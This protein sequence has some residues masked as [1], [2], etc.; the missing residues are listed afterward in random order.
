MSLDFW[1][2]TGLRAAWRPRNPARYRPL[3]PGPRGSGR[4][5]RYRAGFRG[6]HAALNPVPYQK[7]NDMHEDSGSGQ[8]PLPNPHRNKKIE[9]Q[10]PIVETD[11]R[12]RSGRAVPAH[13]DISTHDGP[14]DQRPA[15]K[16]GQRDSKIDAAVGVEENFPEEPAS[17]AH[18]QGIDD[19][20]QEH[21][22]DTGQQDNAGAPRG[23]EGAPGHTVGGIRQERERKRIEEG[24][25]GQ[26]ELASQC[27]ARVVIQPEGHANAS[28]RVLAR[29]GHEPAPDEKPQRPGRS[30]VAPAGHNE[31][32]EEDEDIGAEEQGAP[33]QR[34][35]H[36]Q[37]GHR[38][39]Y[40]AIRTPRYSSP[41]VFSTTWPASA[42]RYASI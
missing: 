41:S 35:E 10:Y 13:R 31:C 17:P 25:I 1:Y 4:R 30:Q 27:G 18:G 16:I 8:Q 36:R 2:G 39:R 23:A 11:P 21:H 3:R 19:E 29:E 5:G 28:G 20:V 9:E 32:E 15:G 26:V 12:A 38:R 7:S 14:P 6:R 40:S 34:E 42:P 33:E 37:V 22:Q 24:N